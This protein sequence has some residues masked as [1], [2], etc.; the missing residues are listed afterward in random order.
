MKSADA[1]RPQR[2]AVWGD[3]RFLLGI[4]LVVVS[5]VGVWFVIS[6]ARQTAPVWAAE[7]T[8]VPG[9]VISRDDLAVV[10]VALGQSGGAYV[11]LDDFTDGVVATRT[12]TAGELLPV[13]AVADADSVRTANVVVRSSAD[14]A[15]SIEPGTT[16][17]LWSAPLLERGTY[18]TPRI[19]VADATVAAVTRDDSAIAGGGAA[20]EL[21]IPR[22]EVAETLAAIADQAALSVVGAGA[23]S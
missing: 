12:V 11:A 13:D 5:I 8:L 10:E 18:D 4:L 7:R 21:V 15:A 2:R 19:L 3:T 23:G 1:S 14:V 20:L 6:S 9:E 16:V 17:E 22:S